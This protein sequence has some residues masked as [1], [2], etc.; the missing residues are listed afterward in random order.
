M[1]SGLTLAEAASLSHVPV[2][3][4]AEIEAGGC[5]PTKKMVE[6][7]MSLYGPT[8]RSMHYGA[9]QERREAPVEGMEIDW[10]SLVAD[11]ETLSNR[12]I[13]D[14]VAAAVRELRNLGEHAAVTMREAEADLLVSML[15]LSDDDLSIEIM[16]AFD[17]SIHTTN[18]FLNGAINRAKRRANGAQSPFLARLTQIVPPETVAS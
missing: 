5:G 17:L 18:D 16:E 15:D 3:H 2:T 8:I 13:L 1:I 14:E 4:L 9:A 6:A 10:I 11:S 12:E 7:L